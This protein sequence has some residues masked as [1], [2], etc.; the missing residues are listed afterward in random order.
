M[1]ATRETLS[2]PSKIRSPS[3]RNERLIFKLLIVIAQMSS[4]LLFPITIVGYLLFG[5]TN[6]TNLGFSTVFVMVSLKSL[7]VRLLQ[8]ILG[9]QLTTTLSLRVSSVLS[10][11]SMKIMVR[12]I[13]EQSTH[14]LKN[15]MSLKVTQLIKRLHNLTQK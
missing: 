7:I 9:S 1:G 10:K 12:F 3:A 8:K 2:K 15:S 5:L 13:V 6:F 11:T 14:K 4:R